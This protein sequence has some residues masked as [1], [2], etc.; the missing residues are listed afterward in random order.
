MYKSSFFIARERKYYL[1]DFGIFT[2]MIDGLEG[3]LNLITSLL[4]TQ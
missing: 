1:A 3:E 2:D 4:N